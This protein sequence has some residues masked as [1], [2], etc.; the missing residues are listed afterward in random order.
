MLSKT[1]AIY[2]LWN[3]TSQLTQKSDS[4]RFKGLTFLLT[5]LITLLGLYKP[6]CKSQIKNFFC[7]GLTKM[8]SILSYEMKRQQ[9]LRWTEIAEIIACKHRHRIYRLWPTNVKPPL[10][11]RC[12]SEEPWRWPSD[13]RRNVKLL[14]LN[15]ELNK[16]RSVSQ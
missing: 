3:T 15:N 2:I 5:W 4:I 9:F 12:R 13:Y 1:V 14:E 7:F 16:L 8:K 10:S 11:S 6:L